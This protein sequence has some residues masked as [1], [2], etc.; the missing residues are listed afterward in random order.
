M[1]AYVG[2]D[3]MNA[4]D[5]TGLYEIFIGGQSENA[6]LIGG[7]I[8]RNFAK[9]Y[10]EARKGRVAKYRRHRGRRGTVRALREASD[11]GEPVNVVCHSR[12]CNTA[13]AAIEKSG[14]EVDNLITVD[15]VGQPVTGFRGE[16]PENIKTWINVEGTPVEGEH[17]SA[18]TVEGI[19][20]SLPFSE[21]DASEVDRQVETDRNHNDFS[22]M[23]SDADGVGIIDDSYKEE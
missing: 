12:G 2:N 1:Y 14:V 22:G 8:V 7:K 5:P 4:T 9:A 15:P 16:R 18:D 13:M 17:N 19:G 6:P 10:R 23:L 11:L 20:E 21:F 3:P